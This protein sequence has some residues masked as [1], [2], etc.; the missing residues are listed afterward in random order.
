M[1]SRQS[2]IRTGLDVEHRIPWETKPPKYTVY[3]LPVVD[4][5]DC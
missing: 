3:I 1:S 5:E 4:G 2:G